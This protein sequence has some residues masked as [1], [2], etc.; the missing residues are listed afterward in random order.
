MRKPQIDVEQRVLGDRR[1]C[2]DRRVED[3]Q[4]ELDRRSGQ[5]RRVQPDRRAAR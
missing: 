5:V 2:S 3:R 4:V 1:W